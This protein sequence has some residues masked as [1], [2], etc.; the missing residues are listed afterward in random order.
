M[1]GILI[2]HLSFIV[3]ASSSKFERSESYSYSNY[4]IRSKYWYAQA[5]TVGA[6]GLNIGHVPTNISVY[7]SSYGT[8]NPLSVKIVEFNLTTNKPNKD[9]VF[10]YGLMPYADYSAGWNDINVTAY[11]PLL[12]DTKYAVMLNQSIETSSRYDWYYYNS[13]YTGG[14]TYMSNNYGSTWG[15]TY[16]T[17]CMFQVWGT[18][19]NLNWSISNVSPA[20]NSILYYDKSSACSLTIPYINLSFDKNTTDYSLGAELNVTFEDTMVYYN[21]SCINKSVS[22]NIFQ[23]YNF[24]STSPVDNFV[25]VNNT[26]YN[27]NVTCNYFGFNRT[28]N[29]SFILILN[30]SGVTECDNTSL[31]VYNNT[32]NV[33]GKYETAYSSE[34]GNH[35]WLNFTGEGGGNVTGY[36]E[37]ELTTYSST[38]GV[39]TLIIGMMIRK[40]KKKGGVNFEVFR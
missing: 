15:N 21:N 12:P 36:T 33:S 23:P 26:V 2:T 38:V 8:P 35:I 24:L 18:V 4:D 1:I 28:F 14:S 10:A 34:T 31:T 7:L 5:F 27:W 25:L 39:A 6:T 40:K 22:V 11:L 37:E 29:Y 9:V 17:S 13:G 3:S 30:C 20:N 19:L 16:S 32:V